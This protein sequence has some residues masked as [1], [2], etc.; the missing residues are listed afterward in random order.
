[1]LSNFGWYYN[2]VES[3]GVVFPP[4]EESPYITNTPPEQPKPP[5]RSASLPF[6]EETPAPSQRSKNAMPGSKRDYL[7]TSGFNEKKKKLYNDLLVVLDNI[8]LTNSIINEKGD[9]EILS[10]MVSNLNQMEAKFDKLK[11]KLK[12]VGEKELF[13]FTEALLAEIIK[14]YKRANAYAKTRQ[15]GGF[16]L[17]ADFL[18]RKCNIL[19]QY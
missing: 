14:T 7:D 5:Q 11:E 10:T 8:D 17:A 2:I 15:T 4:F 3:K 6:D 13:G 12:M 16:Y 9:R 18:D 19:F 1:M